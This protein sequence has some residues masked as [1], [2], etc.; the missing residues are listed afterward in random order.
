MALSQKE[1]TRLCEL[2]AKGKRYCTECGEIKHIKEFHKSAKCIGGVRPVC[3][4]CRRRPRRQQDRTYNYSGYKKI[5]DNRSLVDIGRKKCSQCGAIKALQEF[6]KNRSGLGGREAICKECKGKQH[7][8]S[9]GKLHIYMHNRE[10]SLLIEEGKKRCI[11]CNKILP[12]SAFHKSKTH[13]AGVKSTCK[14]CHRKYYKKYEQQDEVKKRR[15]E[16]ENT[17]N[18]QLKNKLKI[19]MSGGMRKSLQSGSKDGA[20]WESLVDYTLDDLKQHLESQF[21]KNMSWDNYGKWHIDHIRPVASFDFQSPDDPG[22]KL[23]W[24]LENLRPMWAKINIKKGAQW[25]YQLYLEEVTVQ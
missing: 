13:S 17:R 22:F 1:K 23:C 11:S 19:A 21:W 20:H 18:A 2:L 5:R 7:A 15:R 4:D 12:L 3:K 6:Y 24:A 10:K 8:E 16:R 9:K 14:E 25:D